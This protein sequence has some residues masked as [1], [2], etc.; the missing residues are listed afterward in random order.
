MFP[1]CI[2]CNISPFSVKVLSAVTADV[3]S[4][5]RTHLSVTGRIFAC[6]NSEV[7]H[8]ADR[9]QVCRYAQMCSLPL[10]N[11]SKSCRTQTL[12]IRNQICPHLEV[13]FCKRS[14]I[15]R[16]TGCKNRK[17]DSYL[18][19]KAPDTVPD[20]VPDKTQLKRIWSQKVPAN[21]NSGKCD[22]TKWPEGIIL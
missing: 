11:S 17:G 4:A 6:V 10:A 15:I 16:W 18:C 1:R 19:R 9:H 22:L 14:E 7:Q 3:Y 20:T 21:E 12:S 5:S 2:F 8:M 13:W